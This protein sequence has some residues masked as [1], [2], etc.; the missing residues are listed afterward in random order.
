ML[1]KGLGFVFIPL[2]PLVLFLFFGKK[3]F[4]LEY[5][6]TVKKMR[7]HWHAVSAGPVR[8]Y[9]EDV[10]LRNKNIPVQIQGT[11][12]QCGNCCLNKQCVF[13]EPVAEDKFQCGIYSSP[14]RRFSNCNSYPLHHEDIAR[15]NCPSFSVI[16]VRI[17]RLAEEQTA[18]NRDQL[19]NPF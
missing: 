19:P 14:W 7:I 4:L 6:N 16:P 11:C 9:F 17:N 5:A 8:H 13:L 3:K 1:G 2:S 18:L 12:V 10:F 15:Y